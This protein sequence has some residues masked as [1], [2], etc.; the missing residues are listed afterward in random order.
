M[1]IK[2]YVFSMFLIA[3]LL[4][5]ASG[6]S[7]AAASL[8]AGNTTLA[9]EKI[10]P[11]AAYTTAAAQTAYEPAGAV[12]VSSVLH[13]SL[14]PGAFTAASN[15]QLCAGTTAA[16]GNVVVAAAPNNTAVDLTLTAPLA[17]GQVYTLS[18]ANDVCATAPVGLTNIQIAA[19]SAAGTVLTMTVDNKLLPGDPNIFAT[20]TVVT[21]VNQFTATLS[22]V[23]SKL[24]FATN[25][26]SFVNPIG[27]AVPY[28]PSAT[29]SEAALTI[30]SNQSIND[31]VVVA[32]GGGA[33]QRI[34]AA[35]DTFRFKI[36]GDLHGIANVKFG[37]A[38]APAQA[39]AV[40]AAD[41]TAGNATLN[42]TGAAIFICYN[43]DTPPTL[44]ALELTAQNT[45]VPIV[46]GNRTLQ[47]TI[48]G[49]GN[50]VAAYTRD[51]VAA[52][53][54]SHIITLDA[55]QYYIPVVIT[56]T[57]A[58]TYIKFQS[59]TIVSGAN[60]VS[61]TVLCSDGTTV[62]ASLGTITSGVPFTVTGTQ[63]MGI[64]TA[65]GKTVSG[66]NG[67]AA[68]ITVNTPEA[69]TFR[70]ANLCDANGC[71]IL[72]VPGVG[73]TIFE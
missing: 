30:F 54:V 56:G 6:S 50:I 66:T 23:T 69:D 64:A 67:F 32:A 73:I 7:F 44:D 2:K 33:C 4:M 40:T 61:G 62:T 8:N 42:V 16:S 70:Y 13:I 43:T 15:L 5:V 36:T 53:T 25:E 21:V 19:G 46:T 24:N 47:M 9:A 58:E 34:T 52:G 14:S 63:L 38:G 31:K 3:A 60:G 28:T 10:P 35:G 55:K 39:Y 17:G 59:K 27:T 41:I 20:A 65:A 12:A 49:G 26:I 48:L 18:S 72:N 37:A 22:A 29:Q 71:R 51:L 45:T 11:A 57:G 68:I 1:R